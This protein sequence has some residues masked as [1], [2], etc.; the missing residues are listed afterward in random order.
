MP[1]DSR[2]R[3]FT[4]DTARHVEREQV[5][6]FFGWV[7]GVPHAKSRKICLAF[8]RWWS[9]ILLTAPNIFF[10]H[11]SPNYFQ[12]NSPAPMLCYGTR[13]TAATHQLIRDN[14]HETPNRARQMAV[15]WG[16]EVYS[17]LCLAK[18]LPAIHPGQM[19][20]NYTL[21]CF[22]EGFHIRTSSIH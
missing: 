20:Y 11:K 2:T 8:V 14:L 21:N 12:P 18:C 10:F 4:H 6:D 17:E 9:C 7:G 1:G 19:W 3:W 5:R 15:F 16:R 22:D 13:T